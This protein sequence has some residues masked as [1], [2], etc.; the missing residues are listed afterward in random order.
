MTDK[1]KGASACDAEPLNNSKLNAAILPHPNTLRW[2]IL[3]A[4]QVGERLTSLEAWQRFGASRLSAD[5][6]ALRHAGHLI[7]SEMIEVTAKNGRT[8]KVAQYWMAQEAE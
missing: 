3:A 8:A 5:V 2:Q 7:Q 6:H 1:I 4:F